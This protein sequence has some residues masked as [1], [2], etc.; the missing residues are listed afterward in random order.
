MASG[1][2]SDA[3]LLVCPRCRHVDGA[4]D[5]HLA[6]LRPRGHVLACPCG[7]RYPLV[8]GIPIVLADVAAWAE[9][10]GLEALRRDVD[11]EILEL[12]APGGSATT[13]NRALAR[14]Y[15]QAPASPFR[16]WISD[17]LS[18]C[19]GPV[20]ELGSGPGHPGTI[21]LDLNFRLLR[22]GGAAIP[23]CTDADGF[24]RLPPG[25]GLVADA[26]DPPFPPAS[27]A[28]VC[29]VNV[30]DSC[31]DPFTVL[32]QAD[33]LVRPGGTLIVTCAYAFDDS[34]TP[35]DKR[36]DASSLLGALSS[37]A[38]FGGFRLECRAQRVV[39]PLPWT[40]SLGPRTAHVHQVQAIVAQKP[41]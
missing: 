15:A 27:F 21:R 32:A 14:V 17:E 2:A 18:R 19:A 38:A 13:R 12:L 4:G 34:V 25:S 28:T 31:R 7:A 8:D 3:V 6:T 1:A 20:L 11:D 26:L 33:A 30:L 35:R 10:E 16:T 22:L 37:G 9:T 36:F 29:V 5:L 24:A 40:L 23:P 41:G 39:D